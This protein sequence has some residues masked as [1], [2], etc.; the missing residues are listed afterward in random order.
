MQTIKKVVKV[1]LC[2]GIDA[3]WYFGLGSFSDDERFLP[4]TSDFCT[5][6]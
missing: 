4:E 6:N 2:Q 5:T 3:I 1:S